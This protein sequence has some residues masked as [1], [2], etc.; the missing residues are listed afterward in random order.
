MDGAFHL[1]RPEY[2]G[3]SCLNCHGGQA[4]MEVHAGKVPA[5]L[6]N[7]GGAI[8]VTILK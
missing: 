4:G 5:E 1:I 2:V 8:S 3:I 7:F 6:D